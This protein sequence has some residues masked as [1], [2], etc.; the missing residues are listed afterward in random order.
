M[1]FE[2]FPDS[3]L[4]VGGIGETEVARVATVPAVPRSLEEQGFNHRIAIAVPVLQQFPIAAALVAVVA[5]RWPMCIYIEALHPAIAYQL[6]GLQSHLVVV[7]RVDHLYR[8]GALKYRKHKS[9]IH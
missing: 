9:P 8:W 4:D 5:G 7:F 3:L 1:G 2:K 6:G